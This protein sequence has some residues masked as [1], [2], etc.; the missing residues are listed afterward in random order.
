[1][2]YLKLNPKNIFNEYIWKQKKIYTQNESTSAYKSTCIC[3]HGPMK[4]ESSGQLK[5]YKGFNYV[6]F[7]LIMD[8]LMSCF[9]SIFREC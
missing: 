1:M 6:I 8:M 3:I 4:V 7:M 9:L 5:C 2:T